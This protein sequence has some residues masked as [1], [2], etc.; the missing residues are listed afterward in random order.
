MDLTI[1]FNLL[2]V[3]VGNGGLRSIVRNAGLTKINDKY[4]NLLYFYWL[5]YKK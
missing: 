1:A 2:F 4:S 5:R 3:L